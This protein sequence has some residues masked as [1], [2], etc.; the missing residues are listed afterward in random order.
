MNGTAASTIGTGDL[1]GNAN[2]VDMVGYGTRG[3]VRGRCDRGPA[4]Q[5]DAP[6]S[7]TPRTA[8]SDNNA[9][10]FSDGTPTP[11]G[12]GGVTPPPDEFTGT[13]AE[14]QGTGATSPHVG[15]IATTRG[16]VTAAY[17][18]GGLN[19]FYIQT[20]GTGGNRRHA[21][22]LGCHLRVRLGRHR[23]RRHR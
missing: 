2:L 6:H 23:D 21:R 15:D 10:D 5:H 16:V 4:H 7:A 20:E 9:D 19:G 13:I 22:C 18:T 12:Q 8:D 1:A 3:L 11:G 14:I 17:P